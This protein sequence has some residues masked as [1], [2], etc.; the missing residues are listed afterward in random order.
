MGRLFWKLFL[1]IWLGQ[2]AAVFG[3]ATLFWFEH[4]STAARFEKQHPPPDFMA[5]NPSPPRASEPPPRR[6]PPPGGRLPDIGPVP[7]FPLLA[8]L[9]ASVLCAAAMAWYFAKPIRH[10]RNA[11]ATAA[12][13]NLDIR[14]GQAMGGRRDELADLGQ[15]FDR[16]TE[17]LQALIAGQK[18][19][20]HDVSHELRSPLARLQAAIGLVRQQPARLDETLPRLE[21]EGE[22][23]NLLIGELLTL[24]RLEAGVSGPQ[25]TVDLGE[26]LAGIADDARFEGVARQ[27]GIDF[28]ADPNLFVHANPELLHRAIENVVRNALRFSPAGADVR[29]SARQT[30]NRIV[31]NIADRGEGVPESEREAIFIPFHRGQ[32]LATGDGY[33]LGLAIARQVIAALSGTIA[34]K[35]KPDG[36]AGLLIEIVLPAAAG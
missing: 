10:L 14:L 12:E 26:L 16:M 35:A 6:P 2:M 22:R 34:A 32:H 20:L 31:L 27:I 1:F 23:M 24:S 25:E 19:L 8:G 9:V 30:G 7:L 18:R 15:D 11:F 29:I 17:R 4:Q 33:G 21:R 3:T 5:R 13:G 36:S 28:S